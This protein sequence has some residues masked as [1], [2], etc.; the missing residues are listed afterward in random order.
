MRTIFI[1]NSRTILK[2]LTYEEMREALSYAAS[3]ADTSSCS[4][5]D[6]APRNSSTVAISIVTSVSPS[7]VASV[8]WSLTMPIRLGEGVSP[9][10]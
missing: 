8:E 2:G 7:P 5:V 3:T 6:C 1:E 4:G 10:A 9:S